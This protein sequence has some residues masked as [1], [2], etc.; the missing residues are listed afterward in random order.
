[1]ESNDD[2]NRW[3]ERDSLNEQRIRYGLILLYYL[4]RV[5]LVLGQM[6][7]DT[8]KAR[9]FLVNILTSSVSV[10]IAITDDSTACYCES[11]L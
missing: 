6:L 4:D 5:Y 7:Q 8:E 9:V 10:Y 1:M 2:F 3:R 11:L